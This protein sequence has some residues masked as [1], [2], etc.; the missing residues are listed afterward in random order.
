MVRE[1]GQCQKMNTRWFTGSVIFFSNLNLSEMMKLSHGLIDS[2]KR[3][4]HVF[5]LYGIVPVFAPNENLITST[6]NPPTHRVLLMS[7][8]SY[9]PHISSTLCLIHS[10]C[11]SIK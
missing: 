6:N 8:C 4:T 1:T 11:Y 2:N 7:S 10:C 9:E 3:R 5:I